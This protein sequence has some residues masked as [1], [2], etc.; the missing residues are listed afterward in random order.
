MCHIN[1]ADIALQI[2]TVNGQDVASA[3]QE[4][5]AAKLKVI[6]MLSLCHEQKLEIFLLNKESI[7]AYEK[8]CSL[9]S[10]HFR[11]ALVVSL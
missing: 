9:C 11:L 2:L 4:D 10:N 6:I 5:V 7:I 8:Q 3:M 1:F